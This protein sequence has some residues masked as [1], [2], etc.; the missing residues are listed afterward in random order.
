MILTD[1]LHPGDV[2]GI[3][4][5]S[6]VATAESYAPMIATLEAMGYRV[7]LA[8]NLYHAAWG[9]ASS[10]EDRAADF[11]QLV[12][13][14]EVKLIAFG[15]GE[16]AVDVL[17]LIDFEA[18]RANPK[19]YLSYSDG[20]DLL[21]TIWSKCGVVTF[22]GQCPHHSLDFA[23]DGQDYNCRQ[24][25]RMLEAPLPDAHVS[26]K[27]WHP[28]VSGVCEGTLC[29]GYLDNFVFLN[30]AGYVTPPKDEPILLFIEDHKMFFG[31]EHESALLSRLEQSPIM[32]Q[33]TGLL[34]GHY[35]YPTDE[36]LLERLTR[37]G[38]KWH[39][40]V[41]YCDDFGHGDSHAILPIGVK[42][43]MDVD[44]QSLTYLK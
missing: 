27:P 6:H 7:R 11:N 10:A 42:A 43:R 8:D 35:G 9:Y 12:R 25:R 5:P 41:A 24:F 15:G 26:A 40:P 28:L 23:P 39:I 19:R 37:L 44:H 32:R 3:C 4:S 21:N 16:G 18:A 29:G 34:F 38:Q 20:T 31:I 17:P 14:P 22:Y 30:C 36:Q 1:C 33:V 13:D 2:I